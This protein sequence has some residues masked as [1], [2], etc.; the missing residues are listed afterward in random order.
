MKRL[1]VGGSR[2]SDNTKKVD[3]K[4]TPKVYQIKLQHSVSLYQIVEGFIQKIVVT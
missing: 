2:L 3:E 4:S 1:V